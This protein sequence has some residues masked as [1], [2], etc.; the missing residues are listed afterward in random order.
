MVPPS[1]AVALAKAD[2]RA[3]SSTQAEL[4]VRPRDNKTTRQHDWS[5]VVSS[6]ASVDPPN[7]ENRS[8]PRRI[9]RGEQRITAPPKDGFAV[10]NNRGTAISA[11]QRLQRFPLTSDFR[12]LTSGF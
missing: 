4:G 3:A 6:P 8:A 11:F 1:R 2:S 5:P 7:T 9:R 10:A 12:P